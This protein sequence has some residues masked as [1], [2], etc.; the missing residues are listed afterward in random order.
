[1]RNIQLSDIAL[2][3]VA[4]ILMFALAGCFGMALKEKMQKFLKHRRSRH[5]KRTPSS[6]AWGCA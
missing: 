4:T 2:A 6:M 5:T 3:V 1:M